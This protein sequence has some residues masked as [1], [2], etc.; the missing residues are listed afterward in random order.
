MTNALYF[1]PDFIR[2]LGA[3]TV[4]FLLRRTKDKVSFLDQILQLGQDIDPQAIAKLLFEAIKTVNEQFNTHVNVLWPLFIDKL[5]ASPETEILYH[6][7]KFCGEHSSKDHLAPLIE[8][9]FS[10][11]TEY[12]EA[13]NHAAVNYLLKCLKI[14]VQ[15]KAGKLIK[16]PGQFFSLFESIEI[17]SSEV[18][19]PIF[20]Q[21]TYYTLSHF[22]LRWLSWPLPA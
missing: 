20:I 2:H 8:Q 18:F 9:T 21:S 12:F 5:S 3:E 6:I 1:R 13:G 11:I 10:K 4:A 22:I 17:G 7:F 14:Q 15:L 19:S 16:N